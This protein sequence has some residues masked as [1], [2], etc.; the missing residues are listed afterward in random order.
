MPSATSCFSRG[1]TSDGASKARD[2]R[3]SNCSVSGANA[4]APPAGPSVL[5]RLQLID[6]EPDGPE[7]E[8][9]PH[10]PTGVAEGHPAMFEVRCNRNTAD[11]EDRELAMQKSHREHDPERDRP[12]AQR[13]EREHVK[14]WFNAGSECF[15]QVGRQ[16]R[17]R[18][19]QRQDGRERQPGRP[20]R[21]CEDP[22]QPDHDDPV[23]DH[24]R[25]PQHRHR[26]AAKRHE[27]RRDPRLD[28]EHVVLAVEKEGKGAQS[29]RCFAMR[30]MMA[31][32]ESKS[33]CSEKRNGNDRKTNIAIATR[34]HRPGRT[35]ACS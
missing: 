23:D 3:L 9:R 8:H 26:G 13:P 22:Q 16:N 4:L 1:T 21:P 15:E 34:L 33:R 7:C 6:G 20:D 32:S 24:E 14:K 19:R 31:W 12:P 18:C 28:T 10:D 25:Q 29:L 5:V 11:G 27:R 35:A 17:R 2:I 30:P